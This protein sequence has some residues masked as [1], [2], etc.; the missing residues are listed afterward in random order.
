VIHIKYD[1]IGRA[2]S[3]FE[4]RNISRVVVEK[5]EEKRLIGRPNEHKIN[6]MEECGLEQSG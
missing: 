5:F 3:T 2:C 4:K 1:K 6:R